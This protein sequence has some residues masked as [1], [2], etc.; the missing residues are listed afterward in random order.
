MSTR[1]TSKTPTI[2]KSTVPTNSNKTWEWITI[3]FIIK[4]PISEGFDTITVITDQL[5]KYIHLI[6]T[7]ETMNAPIIGAIFYLR[8][9][10]LTMGCLK[11]ITSDRDKLFTSKI[12]EI[13]NRFDGN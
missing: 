8:I 9:L 12:L 2:W 6:P 4:L 7:K 1:Q 10:S 5:T 13:T 3:D 11:Y